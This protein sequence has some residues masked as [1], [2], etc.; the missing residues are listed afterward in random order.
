[1]VVIIIDLYRFNKIKQ[2][3]DIGFI[4]YVILKEIKLTYPYIDISNFYL[5]NTRYSA[6]YYKLF[7]NDL[8]TFE[9][10]LIKMMDKYLHTELILTNIIVKKMFVAIEF[11]IIKR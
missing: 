4:K 2:D 9:K 7:N 10:S 5:N 3:K 1:M 11:K 6:K 8:L